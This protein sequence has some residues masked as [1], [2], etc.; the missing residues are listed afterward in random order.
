[1]NSLVLEPK[2]LQKLK[3]RNL[4]TYEKM[5]RFF[6]NRDYDCRYENGLNENY[7]G[8]NCCVIGNLFSI[9]KKEIEKQM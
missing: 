2:E 4:D 3:K 5:A 8:M 1:M 6:P 9:E 7:A